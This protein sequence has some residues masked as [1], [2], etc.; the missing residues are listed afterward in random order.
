MSCDADIET[1][2]KQNVLTVPIQ[3]VTAR[4]DKPNMVTPQG[5]Q[6]ENEA[7]VKKERSNKPKEVVF[8]IKDSK[9]KM[10]EV[11]TGISDD[12]Y[13]EILSGLKGDEDVVS[14][15]YRAI[16]KELNEDSKV[17]MQSKGKGTEKK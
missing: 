16:S 8:V 7:K 13:I 1:E 12:T 15:P 5:E 3:S 14:G 4:I 10:V 6:P 9:A 17:S 2:K 11:K